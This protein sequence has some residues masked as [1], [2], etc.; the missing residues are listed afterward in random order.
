MD[1]VRVVVLTRTY[2]M[3]VMIRYP[4]RKTQLKTCPAA[5][6]VVPRTGGPVFGPP[7]GPAR[8]APLVPPPATLAFFPI[9]AF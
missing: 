9:L 2:S 6:G 8:T 3:T 4:H 5:L 7:F 1:L